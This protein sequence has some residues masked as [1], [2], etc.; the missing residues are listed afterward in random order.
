MRRLLIGAD[1]FAG[2]QVFGVAI[3]IEVPIPARYRLGGLLRVFAVLIAA[4]G[5]L[6]GVGHDFDELAVVLRALRFLPKLLEIVIVV[7]LAHH[8]PIF[9]VFVLV[10]ELVQLVISHGPRLV[11]RPVPP[12]E[13][14]WAVIL[15]KHLFSLSL[16]AVRSWGGLIRIVDRGLIMAISLV[17]AL[18]QLVQIHALVVVDC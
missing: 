6:L 16:L 17:L 12:V 2:E 10:I 4:L 13:L 15:F 3:F 8:L 5:L 7:I 11:R 18:T 14:V 1:S 9:L